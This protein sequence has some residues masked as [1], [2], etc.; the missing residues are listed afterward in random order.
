MSLTYRRLNDSNSTLVQYLRKERNRELKDYIECI[1]LKCHKLIEPSESGPDA[2]FMGEF[3]FPRTIGVEIFGSKHSPQHV[4]TV[5]TK[6]Q[7]LQIIVNTNRRILVSTE[8]S[9]AYANVYMY[10]NNDYC[11]IDYELHNTPTAP[12]DLTK[13]IQKYWIKIRGFI[14]QPHANRT[15]FYNGRAYTA[16]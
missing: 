11:A 15:N 12:I 14:N 3:T 7:K 1:T 2:L 5:L 16:K 4:R 9:H 8:R 10:V 13:A 6:L